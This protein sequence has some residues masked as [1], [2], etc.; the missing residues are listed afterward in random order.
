[1]GA[2][3]HPF[4]AALACAALLA[5]FVDP[6]LARRV[7]GWTCVGLVPMMG[8]TLLHVDL[9]RDR[10]ATPLDAAPRRAISSRITAP[11]SGR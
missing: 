7:F 1:M 11:L 5:L 8:L 9:L 4:L 10:S 6:R 3:Y 2:R